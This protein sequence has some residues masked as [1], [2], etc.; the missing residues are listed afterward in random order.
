MEDDAPVPVPFDEIA[1]MA[2]RLGMLDDARVSQMRNLIARGEMD[3]SA[4]AAELQEQVM[5]ALAELM[6]EHGVG[7]AANAVITII[8]RPHPD[9]SWDPAERA[10]VRFHS[11]NSRPDLNGC[12]G[13]L[14]HFDAAAGRWAVQCDSSLEQIRV[15]PT[16]FTLGL[17]LEYEVAAN[18]KTPVRVVREFAAAKLG[19]GRYLPSQFS[20]WMDGTQLE[21]DTFDEHDVVVNKYLRDYGI[22]A[23][24]EV[25]NGAQSP[26]VLHVLLS[27]RPEPAGVTPPE[28]DPTS[29]YCRRRQWPDWMSYEEKVR[30]HEELF[31]E[32]GRY[33][34]PPHHPDVTPIAAFG[35]NRSDIMGGGGA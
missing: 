23:N 25:R 8:L 15:K 9:W 7:E 34:G 29:D 5:P 28:L 24:F 11:L 35:L 26:H 32:D 31:G 14:L 18:G 10:P 4:V 2:I 17:E 6:V 22:K 20:L 33:E 12:T 19:G 13:K 16:N 1:R 30:R 21:I 27:A 3:E